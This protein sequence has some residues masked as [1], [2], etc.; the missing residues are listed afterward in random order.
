MKRKTR[1]PSD[2]VRPPRIKYSEKEQEIEEE[3]QIQLTQ[4]RARLK[5]CLTVPEHQRDYDWWERFP[6]CPVSATPTELMYLKI[7]RLNSI[8][9][10]RLCQTFVFG[11]IP[12]EHRPLSISKGMPAASK[13]NYSLRWRTELPTKE[14]CE[15]MVRLEQGSEEWLDMRKEGIGGS[16]KGAIIG[17]SHYQSPHDVFVKHIGQYAD[18]ARLPSECYFFDEGHYHEHLIARSYDIVMQNYPGIQCGIVA[19]PTI[20][21][22]QTSPD[23]LVTVPEGIH[24]TYWS[25]ND[26]RKGLAEIKAPNYTVHSPR[27]VF[28]FPFHMTGEYLSQQQDQ[29]D[30]NRMPWNDFVSCWRSADMKLPI[31]LPW[32]RTPQIKELVVEALGSWCQVESTRIHTSTVPRAA[33]VAPNLQD[34]LDEKKYL[35]VFDPLE[36]EAWENDEGH[37]VTITPLDHCKPPAV[38]FTVYEPCELVDIICDYLGT[39]PFRPLAFHVGRMHVMRNY[40]HPEFC[41]EMYA[42]VL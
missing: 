16:E 22:C 13:R 26:I 21:E 23:L 17:L 7:A 24:H 5:K 38:Q 28:S 4:W 32:I 12:H 2:D 39:A 19:H 29:S 36:D 9:L 20:P 10:A 11:L 8:Q 25:M 27:H 18:P 35:K 6:I 33:H 37:F 42:R 34:P 40:H 15:K 1:D 30:T 14:Y 31:A 41:E 3:R